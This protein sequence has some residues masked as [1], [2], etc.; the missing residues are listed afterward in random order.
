MQYNHTSY[1]ITVWIWLYCKTSW[2]RSHDLAFKHLLI[3]ARVGEGKYLMSCC[4]EPE[5]ETIPH[6]ILSLP[7]S[8][9]V[10]P[11]LFY[12]SENGPKLGVYCCLLS[13]LITEFNW[14][15]L[16]EDGNPVQLSQNRAHFIIPGNHPG[17]ITITDSF[18][19]FFQ[20]RDQIPFWY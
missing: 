20:N 16:M 1:T 6:P 11:L 3:I 7:A 8:Q 13:A 9:V 18:T 19:T 10:P 17:F 2:K 4:L 12:F 15:L 14:K 5:E